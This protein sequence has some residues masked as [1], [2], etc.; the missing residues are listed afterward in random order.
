MVYALCEALARRASELTMTSLVT[1]AGRLPAEFG[2]LLMRDAAAVE[3]D[4][5][6]TDA[7]HDWVCANSSLLVRA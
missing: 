3:P 4:I 2:V 6:E 7:F 1:L 5:V